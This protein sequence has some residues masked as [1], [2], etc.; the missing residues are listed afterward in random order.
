[1]PRDTDQSVDRPPSEPPPL[2]EFEQRVATLRRQLLRV[3]LSESARMLIEL[4]AISRGV[5]ARGEMDGFA[6]Q[7]WGSLWDFVTT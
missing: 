4:E 2:Q 1:M 5:R 6:D 3:S 7:N